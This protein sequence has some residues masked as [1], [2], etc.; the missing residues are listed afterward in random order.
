MAKTHAETGAAAPRKTMLAAEKRSKD[1]C[2]ALTPAE[3]QQIS[4]EARSL[5]VPT[6]TH[7]RNMVLRALNPG[8][9]EPGR[10]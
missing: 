9:N 3:Y 7:A 5:K 2:I 6:S 8:G 10:R 1:V 4:R